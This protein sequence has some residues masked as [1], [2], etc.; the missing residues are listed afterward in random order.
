MFWNG[1][2]NWLGL[3]SL[4]LV[5]WLWWVYVVESKFGSWLVRVLVVYGVVVDWVL[6]MTGI[7]M[8]KCDGLVIKMKWVIMINKWMDRN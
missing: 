6:V 2:W 4:E 1:C 5:L 8:A 3:V 7:I